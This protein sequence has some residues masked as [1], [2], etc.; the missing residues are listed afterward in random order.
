[1][2]ETRLRYRKAARFDETL[3]VATTCLELKRATIRFGYLITRGEDRV[4]EGE[5]LQASVGHELAPKR[6]P[7]DIAAIF[8]SPEI[9]PV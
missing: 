1:V 5:T 4:C 3:V 8:R 9:A 7:D 6:I 2:V